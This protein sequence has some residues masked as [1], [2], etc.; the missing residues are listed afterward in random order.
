MAL[1]RVDPV[2]PYPL[3]GYLDRVAVYH[4]GRPADVGQR[5]GGYAGRRVQRRP[6]LRFRPPRPIPRCRPARAIAARQAL[7]ATA[8]AEH[9]KSV[10][11][12]SAGV[13]VESNFRMG[14]AAAQNVADC[15]DGKL[16]AEN[17]I[18]KEVLDQAPVGPLLGVL[19]V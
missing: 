7:L 18:N 12:A 1:G 3:A 16:N 10:L 15:F 6:R 9:P 11:R 2:Q 4:A 13:I 8:G 19:R 14:R 5:E 17:V